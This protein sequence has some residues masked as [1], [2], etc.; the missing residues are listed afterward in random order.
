MRHAKEAM[1]CR[2]EHVRVLHDKEGRP[3]I[4][5]CAGAL[6]ARDDAAIRKQSTAVVEEDHPVAEQG[7]ALRVGMPAHRDGRRRRVGES[8]R[9]WRLVAAPAAD[10]AAGA[11][12]SWTH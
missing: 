12:L 4:R 5:R 6:G 7:P 8:R 1:R 2:P 9:T 11:D 10:A 3:R